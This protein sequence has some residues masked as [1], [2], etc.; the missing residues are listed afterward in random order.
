MPRIND[1]PI[2]SPAAGDLVPVHDVST[3]NVRAV[4]LHQFVT[5]LT[6]GKARALL[7]VF[8]LSSSFTIQTPNYDSG[9]AFYMNSPFTRTVT[10]GAGQQGFQSVVIRYGAGAVNL[11]AASGQTIVSKS[12]SNPSIQTQYSAVTL[13]KRTSTEW[14]VIGDI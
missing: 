2:I 11:V 7:Q 10:L 12:G 13:L 9:G 1:Y 8:N 3:G 5:G 14:L 6:D 4:D